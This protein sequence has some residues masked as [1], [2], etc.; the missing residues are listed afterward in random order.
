MEETPRGQPWP[1]TVDPKETVL[2]LDRRRSADQVTGGRP[3]H[4][5]RSVQSLN[6]LIR[7]QHDC[8]R[9]READR[10]GCLQIDHEFEHCG[11]LHRH[12]TRLCTLE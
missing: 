11:L 12:I 8:L 10:I 7:S 1:P 4:M 9:N 6:H 2:L 5:S 3:A